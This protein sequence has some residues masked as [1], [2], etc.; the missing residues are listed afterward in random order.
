MTLP[1]STMPES[2]PPPPVSAIPE[3]TGI[4]VSGEVESLPWEVS[5]WVLS[6]CVELS[7]GGCMPASPQFGAQVSSWIP[8]RPAIAEQPARPTSDHTT[9][10]VSETLPTGKQYREF[11]A[12]KGRPGHTGRPPAPARENGEVGRPT[13]VCFA[14]RL[15]EASTQV[16]PPSRPYCHPCAA[17]AAP[18]SGP[19]PPRSTRKVSR[20]FG[21]SSWSADR[22]SRSARKASRSMSEASRS[23]SQASRSATEASRS[24]NQESRS[25]REASRSAMKVS[26]DSNCVSRSTNRERRRWTRWAFLSTS[27]SKRFPALCCPYPWTRGVSRACLRGFNARPHSSRPAAPHR[28]SPA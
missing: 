26:R 24:M 4:D 23:T 16:L 14:C 10:A 19:G 7:P 27:W 21:S 3:S 20:G 5:A 8:S 13:T 28:T 17:H 9:T 12:R 15:G 6:P 11:S 18:P 2:W 1:V 22:V 25:T